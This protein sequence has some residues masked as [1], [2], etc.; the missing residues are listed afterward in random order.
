MSRSTGYT[1]AR[2]RL[3]TVGEIGGIG[4]MA[5]TSVIHQIGIH[6]TGGTAQ[7]AAP[8]KFAHIDL[9][10]ATFV[11]LRSAQDGDD[12]DLDSESVTNPFVRVYAPVQP[13]LSL[14]VEDYVYKGGAV[15]PFEFMC[16]DGREELL[17]LDS[18]IV[19]ASNIAQLA[20]TAT[21]RAVCIEVN[22]LWVDYFPSC[23]VNVI[24][25]AGSIEEPVRT[26]VKVMPM[27][28][29][30]LKGGWS[31]EFFQVV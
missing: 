16:Y 20:A 4:Q 23:I 13:P 24:E 27:A 2:G 5:E 6:A 11:V 14:G 17:E 29:A 26:K 19:I 7:P 1:L 21:K 3:S 25:S 9:A 12:G 10:T 30:T 22:G 31:R 8:L 15:Q 28:T 18:G